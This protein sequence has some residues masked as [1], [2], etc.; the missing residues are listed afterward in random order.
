MTFLTLPP[1]GAIAAGSNLVGPD[2]VFLR[3]PFCSECGIQNSKVVCRRSY[4]AFTRRT[5]TTV[6]PVVNL[7]F[8]AVNAKL[9][10]YLNTLAIVE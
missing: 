3:V 7:C 4:D 6:S 10:E 9:R 1:E 2:Q 8:F 5:A